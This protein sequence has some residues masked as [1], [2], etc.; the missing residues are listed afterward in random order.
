MYIIALFCY[1]ASWIAVNIFCHT[2]AKRT[3]CAF[4]FF[5]P[6]KM[7]CI[8]SLIY[9]IS[10]VLLLHLPNT[11][12]YGILH[13]I[14]QTRTLVA[15]SAPNIGKKEPAC[16]TMDDECKLELELLVHEVTAN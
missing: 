15:S 10:F 6:I 12:H 1:L 5:V 14:Y 4:H 8:F 16:S 2:K 7:C 13:P 3:I 11:A 9:Y